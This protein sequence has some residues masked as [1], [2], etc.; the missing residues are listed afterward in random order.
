MPRAERLDERQELTLVVATRRGR[1]IRRPCSASTSVGLERRASR[2]SVERL[3][4]LH[5]V[6]AV[7]EQRR[8]PVAVGGMVTDDHRLSGRVAD[9]GVEADLGELP[10][11]PLGAAP[12]VG[13]VRRVGA[14][15]R[16]A[17]EIL[18]TSEGVIRV[19]VDP[20]QNGG[21]GV[22]HGTGSG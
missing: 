13:V 5:V 7:V 6:V 18:E 8:R 2:H 20:A 11:G 15:A 9:G 19:F 17:Q 22:G 10:G 3:G 4:R 16:D 21:E 12:R 1:R 14:D